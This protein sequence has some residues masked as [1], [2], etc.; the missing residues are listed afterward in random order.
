MP[1]LT[2]LGS[3]EQMETF[4]AEETLE[5]FKK[6]K[7]Q[8]TK[9]KPLERVRGQVQVLGHFDGMDRIFIEW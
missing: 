7:K 9:L 2:V 6:F 4:V 3:R 8:R 1:K 5:D